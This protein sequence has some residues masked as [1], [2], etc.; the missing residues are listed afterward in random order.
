MG[1]QWLRDWLVTHHGLQEVQPGDEGEVYRITR[2]Y[3]E[4]EADLIASRTNWLFAS[5]AFLFSAFAALSDKV[6]DRS[7]Y[8]R[9]IIAL[10]GSVMSVGSLFLIGS[11]ILVSYQLQ[12]SFKDLMTRLDGDPSNWATMGQRLPDLR[13]S[14]WPNR[15]GLLMPALLA[16]S[17]IIMWIVLAS[18]RR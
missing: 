16:S 6:D 13:G 17:L 3:L 15:V 8:V 2:A 18:R 4:T 14:K 5:N 7:G 11:A 10:L 12:W 9:G 1:F